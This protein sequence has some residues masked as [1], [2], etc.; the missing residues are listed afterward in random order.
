MNPKTKKYLSM[1]SSYKL[2]ISHHHLENKK[3]TILKM[4][5]QNTTSQTW[6]WDKAFHQ[7]AHRSLI[8]GGD[9]YLASSHTV[10]IFTVALERNATI[11]FF[12]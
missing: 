10:H 9:E 5:L 2:P 7:N 12:L 6:D 4:N 11:D 1:I 8:L 3:R